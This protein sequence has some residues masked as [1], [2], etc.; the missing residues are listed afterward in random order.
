MFEWTAFRAHGRG[1]NVL[2]D[3]AL[4][5]AGSAAEMAAAAP[6]PA[7]HEFSGDINGL[8]AL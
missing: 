2:G 7:A 1:C 8:A 6:I 5:L 4:R 3:R